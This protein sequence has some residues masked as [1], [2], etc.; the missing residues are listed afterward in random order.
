MFASAENLETFKSDP[1]KYA[2]KYRVYCAYTI[3]QGTTADIDPQ[4]WAVVDGRLYLN[5]N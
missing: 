1:E 5:F 3:S 4:A 2:S